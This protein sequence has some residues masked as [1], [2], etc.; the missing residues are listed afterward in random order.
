[1]G[2]AAELRKIAADL[3]TEAS[4]QENQ[5]RTKCAQALQALLALELLRRK[6]G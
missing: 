4:N 5:K 6:V 1:M 3:R 2:S